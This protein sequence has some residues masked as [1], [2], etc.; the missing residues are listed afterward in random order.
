M[1]VWRMP[2][3]DLRKG[4]PGT[5][6]WC[7][8]LSTKAPCQWLSAE[9]TEWQTHNWEKGGFLLT[10]FGWKTLSG[11]YPFFSYMACESRKLPLN[12]FSQASIARPHSPSLWSPSHPPPLPFPLIK[13]LLVSCFFG[14]ASQKILTNTLGDW[15]YFGVESVQKINW[16]E[17][18]GELYT[19]DG[20]L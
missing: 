10:S 12:H 17:L 3:I 15:I 19:E 1:E 5:E 20:V 14:T 18:L 7:P 9:G 8:L 13:S 4:P 6:L 16:P 2:L 11:L